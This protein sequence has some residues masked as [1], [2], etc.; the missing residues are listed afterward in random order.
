LWI[1]ALSVVAYSHAKF[2]IV[3]PDFGLDPA[4]LRMLKRVSQNLASNPVNF[5]SRKSSQ[6]SSLPF[7]G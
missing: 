3:V 4:R 6:G 2:A 7:H 5:I 1:H